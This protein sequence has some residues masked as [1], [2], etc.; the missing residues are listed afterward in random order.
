MCGIKL[1]TP[2]VNLAD[3]SAHNVQ[4]EYTTGV[5]IPS[6][7]ELCFSSY[8]QVTIDGLA[9]FDSPGVGVDLS[10]LLQLAN[11]SDQDEPIAPTWV[12]PARPAAFQEANDILSWNFTSHSGQTI[13][14]TN[15]PPNTVH[16]L[17][18]RKLPVQGEARMLA[19]IHCR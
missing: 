12:S 6:G 14:Q 17:Q 10:T 5:P 16:D 3:G 18:L 19:S 1:A 8:L 2:P 7:C 4:I 9:V 15:L 13:T 11:P